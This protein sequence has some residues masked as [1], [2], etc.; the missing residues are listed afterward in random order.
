MLQFFYNRNLCRAAMNHYCSFMAAYDYLLRGYSYIFILYSLTSARGFPCVQN[1]SSRRME[2]RPYSWIQFSCVGPR[3]WTGDG[4]GSQLR[5]SIYLLYYVN[6]TGKFY[7]FI[8]V[9]CMQKSWSAFDK[10]LK[11]ENARPV[12][13]FATYR[14]AINET[15]IW[16]KK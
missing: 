11:S 13:F 9:Y 16:K 3:V 4:S 5:L 12:T 2:I 1:I 14:S 7:F 15:H 10:Y 8:C 6:I